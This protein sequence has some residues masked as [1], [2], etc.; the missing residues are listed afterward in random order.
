MEVAGARTEFASTFALPDG[1]MRL[2]VSTGAVRT[3][4]SGEWAPVDAALVDTG[5]A[6]EV[7]SPVTPMR[8]SDGSGD[9]PFATIERDGHTLT[10]EMPFDLPAPD[11][12]GSQLTYADVLPGV[13]LVV[14]VNGDATGFSEVLRVE[15]PEAAAQAE[16]QDLTFPVV[17]SDGIELAAR[18]GGFVAADES[19]DPV[20]VSPT[21]VMWD[22][23]SDV[24]EGAT[25]AALGTVEDADPT[26]AP[27]GDEVVTAIPAEVAGDAV[28]I[29]PDAGI[30]ADPA[31]EWPVY[32][33]PGVSGSLNQRSA[34][35]TVIGNAYN[36]A[37]DEGVGLC[38]R[39]TSTTCS[40]TFQS[41]VLYQFGGLQAVG[42]IEPGEVLSATFAVTGTHSYDCTPRPVTLHAVADFTAATP[43]PGGSYWKPLQ[44]HTIAHRDGCTNGQ[45]PRRI[46]FDATQ[47]ARD[48][49]A[50]NTANASFG[51]AVDES[52]MASWKRYGWDATFS[53]DYNRAPQAPA[54]AR[55]TDPDAA[56]VWGGPRPV[57]RSATPTL[58]GVLHDPDGGAV[59]P[60]FAIDD[61][62]SGAR[63]WLAQDSPAQG[64]GA[65]HSITV[66][67]GVLRDGGTYRWSMAGVDDRGAWGSPVGCELVVDLTPPATP[68][69][70]PVAGMPAVYAEGPAPAG[71]IGVEGRFTFGNGGSADVAWYQYQV[72][73]GPVRTVPAS[74]PTISV[75]PA[76]AGPQTLEVWS[77]DAAGWP[78]PRR[79]HRFT[80]GF[81][82]VSD[83]W[84]LDEASGAT[85]ANTVTPGTRDL[86]VASGTTRADG[87]GREVGGHTGDLALRFDAPADGA[88]TSAPVVRT[89]GTYSVMAFAKLDAVTSTATVVSQDGTHVSGFELGHRVDPAC[90]AGTEGHCW[91]FS[92]PTSDA[93]GASRVVAMST[94]PARAGSWVQLVGVRDAGTGTVRVGVCDLGSAGAPKRGNA[95]LSAGV[96]ASARVGTYGGLQVGR[97]RVNG[98][99]A[100][101]WPG[102]VSQVRTYTGV[103]AIEQ[104][105]VSCLNPWSVLP[106]LD[107]PAGDPAAPP[108][109]PLPAPAPGTPAFLPAYVSSVHR[110]L[111]RRDPWFDELVGRTARLE[112]GHPLDVIPRDLVGSREWKI[113]FVGDTY[114]TYLGRP[115]DDGAFVW[116]DAMER[117]M[118]TF[119]VEIGVLGSAEY[120]QRAGSTDVEFVRALYR[121]LLGRAAGQGD[122]D[123]W[124]PHVGSAGRDAVARGVLLST[125]HLNRVVDG[126]YRSVLG[127]PADP[128]GLS[129]SVDALRAG[130]SVP[131]LLV[132]LAA[133]HE[134]QVARV[135]VS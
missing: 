10:F 6:V 129:G 83:A 75:L 42:G 103:V 86:V 89:D 112:A 68:G 22:S 19:G 101:P 77:L 26:V 125:E 128:A 8:F 50:A 39:A 54:S 70:T 25:D 60:M 74:S 66:P 63:V 94:V 5:G 132:R 121:D 40:H 115:Y 44:T 95:V 11:V 21:P 123:T 81:A 73:G 90:P 1:S 93:A 109:P 110:D 100:H 99:A 84:Q 56:C 37:G 15:S 29:T 38:S 7:A 65:E 48:V 133:S 12:E 120:Y 134:Y 71:G 76:V 119:T 135:R 17:T 122:V 105:R 23:S 91:A 107:P 36:F 55:T 96:A 114:R 104:L 61:V 64:S 97:G 113:Q 98:A 31:T 126:A 87:L 106:A 52:S 34:V 28:T 69:V 85:A 47:M 30:L 88:N 33:D 116:V 57:I 49:A 53:V 72:A 35:R 24:A 131:D 108:P 78:S 124:V 4:V 111:L 45:V 92:V 43:Y 79:T 41:R 127:R 67:S 20:F 13:D 32:I 51:I 58:R 3:E 130:G 59:R 16:L 18:D 102:S 46:E 14:T 118:D 80:V 9:E 27:V 82:G 117:G 2:D 62:G